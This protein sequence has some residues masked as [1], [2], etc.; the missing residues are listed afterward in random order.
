MFGYAWIINAPVNRAQRI[1]D[2]YESRTRKVHVTWT[3]EPVGNMT[4]AELMSI[5]IVGVYM[6]INEEP[7]PDCPDCKGTGIIKGFQFDKPCNCKE[8]KLKSDKENMNKSD[9]DDDYYDNGHWG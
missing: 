7:N 3:P 1:I 9:Y 6:E 2:E 5:G 8:N 4:S